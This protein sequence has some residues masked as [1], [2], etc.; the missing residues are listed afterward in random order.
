M[1]YTTEEERNKKI[2][3]INNEINKTLTSENCNL[4]TYLEDLKTLL[5]KNL[6]KNK[7]KKL[8]YLTYTNYN[9]ITEKNDEYFY[10]TTKYMDE[11]KEIVENY[12]NNEYKETQKY[13]HAYNMYLIT[14]KFIKT[15]N[16][17]NKKNIEENTKNLLNNS[18]SKSKT[19]KE[20]FISN[21]N[22]NNESHEKIKKIEIIEKKQKLRNEKNLKKLDE[23]NI[24]KNKNNLYIE[25]Y[26]KNQKKK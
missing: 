15:M 3:E 20:F 10:T 26:R 17:E 11:L 14:T 22:L 18:N 12:K 19:K 21:N 1:E 7:N 2:K 23:K 9:D 8:L 25:K 5:I 6:E 13:K 24:K 4:C 16:N